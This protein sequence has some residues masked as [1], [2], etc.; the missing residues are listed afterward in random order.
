M[1]LYN[2]KLSKCYKGSNKEIKLIKKGLEGWSFE[3]G[4]RV[5]WVR[6]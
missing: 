2:F 4:I 5:K 6:G 1:W 3:E